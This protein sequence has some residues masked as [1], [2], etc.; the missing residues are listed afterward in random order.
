MLRKGFGWLVLV[1]GAV[2][3]GQQFTA[4]HLGAEP[5]AAVLV[6]A[7]IGVGAAAALLAARTLYRQSR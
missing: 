3:L 1:M 6:T 5:S 4:G 7:G 2:V